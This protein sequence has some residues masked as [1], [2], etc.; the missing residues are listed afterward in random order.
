MTSVRRPVFL[1]LPT[2]LE[3]GVSFLEVPTI[4]LKDASTPRV[5]VYSSDWCFVLIGLAVVVVVV[6]VVAVVA[7]VAVAGVVAVVGTVVA[8]DAAFA[9]ATDAAIV[10]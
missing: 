10:A 2:G 8:L 7:V 4:V 1:F 9:F 3:E 5:L 6:V